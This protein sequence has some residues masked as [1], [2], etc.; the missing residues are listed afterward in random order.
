MVCNLRDVSDTAWFI[1]SNDHIQK[2]NRAMNIEPKT[3][4]QFIL[5]FYTVL[6]HALIMQTASFCPILSL[7]TAATL[8]PAVLQGFEGFC[9]WGEGGGKALDE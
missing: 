8:L 5:Q 4:S 7:G 2:M 9:G 6:F 3:F 1:L